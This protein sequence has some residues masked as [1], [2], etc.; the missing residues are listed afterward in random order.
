MRKSI[1]ILLM[2]AVVVSLAWGPALAASIVKVGVVDFQKALNATTEGVVAKENLRAK[3]K[4]KQDKIDAM[5]AEL[6][7]LEERIASPVIS[8]DA[9]AQLKEEQRQRQLE[10]LDYARSA[11]E[12]QDRENTQLSNRI[13]KGLMEIIR[14]IGREESYTV[15]LERNAGVVYFADTL[16]LTE[17]VVKIY[18]QR[19]QAGAGN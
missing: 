13:L 16:D 17:R 1:I 15:I 12:E 3:H 9:L 18:N 10:I 4:L 5:T 14:E 2:A 8:E 11:K 19:N 7:K 6:K